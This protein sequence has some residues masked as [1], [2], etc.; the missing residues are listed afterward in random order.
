MMMCGS[1]ANENAYKVA[2]MHYMHKKRGGKPP[3]VQDM[4]SCMVN[5]APG[6]PDISIMSFTGAFH[7]R[8]YG[9]LS[10]THS[11]AIHKVWVGVVAQAKEGK[12]E[13][14]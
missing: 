6:S 10:T 12:E 3:S 5:Q 14:M 9:S 7:G 2:C 4:D 13:G 1:C 8:L 11:K